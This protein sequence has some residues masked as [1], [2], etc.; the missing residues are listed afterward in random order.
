MPLVQIIKIHTRAHVV[1]DG[2]EVNVNLK[3]FVSKTHVNITVNV[4][5]IVAPTNALARQDGSV[6]T[7]V[8]L[9][10]VLVILVKIMDTVLILKVL[11]HAHVLMD[12]M[13][14]PVKLRQRV[15]VLH[16]KMEVRANVQVYI[17]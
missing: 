1:T 5:I 16:V 10:S 9:T 13:A 8:T 4:Q 12:G 2:L 3:I 11:L 14:K 7:V 6:K 17:N 15:T